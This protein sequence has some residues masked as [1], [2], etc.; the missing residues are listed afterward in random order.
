MSEVPV[1]TGPAPAAGGQ[2]RSAEGALGETPLLAT[3][4]LVAGVLGGTAVI[5]GVVLYAIAPGFVGLTVANVGFGIVALVFY[6][7]TNWRSLTRVFAGRSSAFAALEVAIV[8]GVLGALAV[9]NWL[10]ALS[11][12]EWDF[13]RDKLFTLQEQSLR[14]ARDLRQPVKIIGFFRSSDAQRTTLKD[15]V[16]LYRR[17][18]GKISLELINPDA[19]PPALVREYGL[20][21]S[22]PRI[23][24]TG[25]NKQFAKVKQPTEEQLT[26]ALLKVGDRPPRKVSFLTGHGEPSVSDDKSESGY[27]H[28][29]AAL[30]D[31]G[32]EV[33]ALSLIDR[34]QVPDDVAV[35]V[36]V[37]AEKPLFPNEVQAV[38]GYL[39]RGGRVVLLLE[40]GLEPGLQDLLVEYGIEVGDNLVVEPN[41]AS[42]AFGFGP[43]APVVQRFEDHP[44]TEPLRGQAVMFYWARSVSPKLGARKVRTTTLLQTGPTSWGET[45]YREGG[46]VALDEA[47]VPG[48]VPLAVA[49]TRDT[50]GVAGRRSDQARLVV[51][52]DSSFA[53]NRFSAMGANGDLF[54]NAVGW[55]A[56]EEDRIT[57]R[58][59]VRGASRMP[60][61]EQQQYGIM[62][63]SVNLLPLLILGFGFSVWAIRRR[64]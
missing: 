5:F 46:E 50:M 3:V 62:F 20:G 48:P 9:A 45:R 23:V 30:H 8:V 1:T 37:A 47:D 19:A 55:A 41:P 42:R 22:G 35:L 7:T 28:A 2:A 13:T 57:L 17:A 11:D 10:A 58:P 12:V 15:L 33:G 44:I 36:I 51:V 32:Y 4:G 29:A 34:E 24:V 27:Q 39:D 53:G 64:R 43:D 49:V 54:A 61:T 21:A 18:S 25:A 56:G 59:K 40:P 6:L 38:K 16:D 26:N 14:V 63:F 31:E 60:L 52:G